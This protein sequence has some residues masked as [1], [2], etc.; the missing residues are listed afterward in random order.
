MGMLNAMTTSNVAEM[1]ISLPDIVMM[2]NSW[3]EKSF[4]G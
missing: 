1:V 2:M 3:G 4:R